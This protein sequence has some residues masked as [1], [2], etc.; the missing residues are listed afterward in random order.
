MALDQQAREVVLGRGQ[1]AAVFLELDRRRSAGA[2]TLPLDDDLADL[3][4]QRLDRVR[5]DAQVA[6]GVHEPR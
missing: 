4:H 2:Q 6:G 3:G 1:A 5:D